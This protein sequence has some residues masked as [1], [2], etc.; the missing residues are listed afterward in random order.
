MGL[1]LNRPCQSEPPA[2]ARQSPAAG[3]AVPRR[4]APVPAAPGS[5]PWGPGSACG[6]CW[7]SPRSCSTRRAAAPPRR[8]G[9]P[10]LAAGSVTAMA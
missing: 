7:G 8:V 3:P 1:C 2:A 10:A 5:P 9:V 4:P 6:C